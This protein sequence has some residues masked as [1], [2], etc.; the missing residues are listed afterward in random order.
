MHDL[1]IRPFG[2]KIFG[3]KSPMAV[4]GL[5]F[6]AKQATIVKLFLID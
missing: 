6:A 2:S 4:M 1:N 3:H 5:V